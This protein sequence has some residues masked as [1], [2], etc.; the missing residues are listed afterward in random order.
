MK[1][2]NT[3][4][5]EAEKFLKDTGTAFEAKFVYHGPYFDG[6]KEGRDVYEIVLTRGKR[7]PFRFKFGQSINNSV[8]PGHSGRKAPTA[9]DVLSCLT[10]NDPGTFADFCS[11]YGYDEDSRKAEKTYFAVQEEWKGVERLFSDVLEALQGIQ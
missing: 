6:D 2:T 7:K 4:E 11:E 1:T 8:T 3:Y 5:Q 9:Y 10:K